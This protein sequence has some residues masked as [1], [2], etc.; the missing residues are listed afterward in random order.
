MLISLLCL[1]VLV[2]AWLLLWCLG[3]IAAQS[4][5]NMKGPGERR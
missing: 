2:L 3:R 4:D 1:S 5:R